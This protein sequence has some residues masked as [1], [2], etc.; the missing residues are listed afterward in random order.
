MEETDEVVTQKKSSL[1][2]NLIKVVLPLGLGIAIIY[3]LIS[4]IDPS[5]L[6]EIL[7]DANWGIL[8]FSLLFGLLGNTIR[9]YRWALFIT[10][11]GYSPKIS[12]LN[13]A[14]YGG[15]AVNF[16]LPRAGEIWRCGVIAKEDN[17]PFSKLF[18]TMILDRIFD[19]ITVA[20]ISLVAFLFNMQ[21]FL[22]QL[23]QNQTTFNTISGI[24]KSPLLYLAIGAAI[25]TTYIVFRFFK[26][27]VI[28][29]KIKGFLSS[30]ASDLKAIWK[31]NTKGRVFLY[32]I[33]IWGSYFC[34]FYITFFAFDFTADLGIT[35]GLIAFALSSI[36]MGV[37]S[38]GGLGPWQ[39]AVIASL[40]LYGVD[41][42]HATA[43]ATG[44]F[45]V[46]SIWVIICGLFGIAMLALKK[47]KK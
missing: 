34:Y 47:Q 40:S 21:F 43:F 39:I 45:A 35:A 20:I 33:G 17:I 30:I 24:F 25:I 37:P 1:L 44:V 16:A 9:G 32:T 8:L 7:K 5:Q 28:V 38:N 41:K 10:P 2:N 19:T 23:E 31:M 11:L 22:T 14:I 18:G 6:W 29:R 3:Y 15:Y 12:N 26:E 4:K 13:Y 42:L 46:Q 27:N 36:S